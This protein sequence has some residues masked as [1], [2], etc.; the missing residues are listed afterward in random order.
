MIW[1][2][3]YSFSYRNYKLINIT[4]ITLNHDIVVLHLHVL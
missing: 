2:T 1:D 4:L 3:V